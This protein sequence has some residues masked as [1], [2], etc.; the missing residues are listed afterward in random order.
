MDTQVPDEDTN[1][2]PASG[3]KELAR[4]HGAAGAQD[5]ERGAA[6]ARFF[7]AVH[8]GVYI[9]VIGPQGTE[10]IAA[11]PHL[12]LIFGFAPDAADRDVRPFDT[13]RFGDA[14]GR[15]AFLDRLRTEGSV[16]D[17]LLRLRKDDSAL[18]WIEVTASAETVGDSIRIEALIRDVSDRK[19]LEDYIAT[20]KK[21]TN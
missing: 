21:K 13:E 14:S 3:E 1:T 12:K 17:Y 20:N 19:K 7:E 10:T 15:T 18:I 6:F 8:E 11:N 2:K 5:A 9:G 4:D 16:S